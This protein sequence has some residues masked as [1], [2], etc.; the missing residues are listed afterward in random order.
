MVEGLLTIRT[1]KGICK[2]CVVG[3]HPEHK[4]DQGK[5]CHASSILGLLNYDIRGPIPI[6]SMNGYWYVLNLIDDFS[7]YTWVFFIKKKYEVLKK[8]IELKA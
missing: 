7:R 5:A 3:K 8:F 2:G 4:F 1:T 6:T